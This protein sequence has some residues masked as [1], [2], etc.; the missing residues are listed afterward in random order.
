LFAGLLAS[1]VGVQNAMLGGA[2]ALGITVLL[3]ALLSRSRHA[4]AP[5]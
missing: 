4:P 1:V 2:V 5:T 3:A